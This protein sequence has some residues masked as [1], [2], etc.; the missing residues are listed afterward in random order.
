MGNIL[1]SLSLLNYCKPMQ[2]FEII[3]TTIVDIVLPLQLMFLTCAYIE[4]LLV[5]TAHHDFGIK[6]L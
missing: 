4:Q 5:T 3:T 1:Q 6:R 2:M